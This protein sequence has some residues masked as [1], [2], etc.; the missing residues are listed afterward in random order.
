MGI[1]GVSIWVTGV[2][3]I[4]L[5][6]RYTCEAL[7]TIQVSVLQKVIVRINACGKAVL[8]PV[9]MLFAIA[10][11]DWFRCYRCTVYCCSRV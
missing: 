2:V 6:S 10:T 8:Q 5:Q 9:C 3:G 11:L 1:I 7:L 4:L